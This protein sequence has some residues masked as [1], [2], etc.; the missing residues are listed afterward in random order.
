MWFAGRLSTN[1]LWIFGAFGLMANA[2]VAARK[3]LK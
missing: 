3:P 1:I 2:E